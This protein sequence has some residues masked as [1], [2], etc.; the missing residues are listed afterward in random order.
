M[1][2]ETA[3]AY[4]GQNPKAIAASRA[5]LAHFRAFLASDCLE[6]RDPTQPHWLD[7]RLNKAAAQRKLTWLV[8]MA[9]NRKAGVPDVR[10]RKQDPDYLRGLGHDAWQ[11]NRPRLVVRRFNTPELNRRLAHRLWKETGES[12]NT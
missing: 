3:G 4:L 6:M 10:G 5:L 1:K 12:V 9:V 7:I 11:A 8:N 2:T